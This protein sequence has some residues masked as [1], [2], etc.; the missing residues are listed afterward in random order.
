MAPLKGLEVDQFVQLD[1]SMDSKMP[2][3]VRVVTEG[4]PTFVTL[5]GPL[6]IMDPKMSDEVRVVTESFLRLVTLVW[7]LSSVA[8][9]MFHEECSSVKALIA[10]ATFIGLSPVWIQR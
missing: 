2:D 7:P 9:L 5:I 3:K 1:S 6:S 10:L 4:F 8:P